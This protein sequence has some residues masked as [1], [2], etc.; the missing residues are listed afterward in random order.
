MVGFH[1]VSHFVVCYVFSATIYTFFWN[2]FDFCDTCDWCD[3]WGES[4]CT[5]L[6][7]K[8]FVSAENPLM[9]FGTCCTV[10]TGVFESLGTLLTCKGPASA[11]DPLMFFGCKILDM[12]NGFSIGTLLTCKGFISAE[13][14]LVF[15]W[16]F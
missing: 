9:F 6:T 3:W 14:P 8:G 15:F 5:L 13:N 11:E 1:V 4:L 2:R 16:N 7:C 10:V 12:K